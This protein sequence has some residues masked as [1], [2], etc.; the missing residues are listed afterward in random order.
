MNLTISNIRKLVD[1]C[2][3]SFNIQ[4]LGVALNFINYIDNGESAL[5]TLQKDGT[6]FGKIILYT[7][8]YG[9]MIADN[10]DL[11]IHYKVYIERMAEIEQ[12]I[13]LV[14]V[15]KLLTGKPLEVIITQSLSGW[16]N[17]KVLMQ[18]NGKYTC[19]HTNVIKEV[20]KCGNRAPLY[21]KNAKFQSGKIIVNYKDYG[22]TDFNIGPSNMWW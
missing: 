14:V 2:N 21:I 9:C 13:T 6:T 11:D 5:F 19:V 18:A 10:D 12:F 4:K 17:A 22:K 16:T 15:H 20:M 3:A 8:G 7:T 1:N